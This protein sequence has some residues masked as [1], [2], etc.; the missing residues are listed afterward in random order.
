VDHHWDFAVFVRGLSLDC[1]LTRIAS[2][3]PVRHFSVTD[4]VGILLDDP[5][6][7]D[8]LVVYPLSKNEP[9]Q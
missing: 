1:R 7:F 4:Y 2:Y 6:G 3:F 9:T 5:E 8:E